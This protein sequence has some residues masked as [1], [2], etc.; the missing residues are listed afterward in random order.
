MFSGEK[1][2]PTN[3]K[4]TKGTSLNGYFIRL[5]EETLFLGSYTVGPVT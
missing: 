1:Y 3:M 4:M 2:Q 5:N